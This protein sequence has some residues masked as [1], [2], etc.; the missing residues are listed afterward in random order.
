MTFARADRELLLFVHY[1]L[2][3][4]DDVDWTPQ[5]GRWVSS[6]KDHLIKNVSERMV[7]LHE[8]R[9]KS[10]TILRHYIKSQVDD[11]YYWKLLAPIYSQGV[12]DVLSIFLKMRET[13]GKLANLIL[14][15]DLLDFLDTGEQSSNI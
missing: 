15:I 9:H 7:W 6:D 14:F 11:L 2:S 1:A 8:L 4:T 10:T 3:R 5:L 13:W 12:A